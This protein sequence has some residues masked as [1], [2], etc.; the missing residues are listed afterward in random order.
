MAPLRGKVALV[1]GAARRLGRRLSLGLAEA[2]AS[3][4]LHY[5]KSEP[6]ASSLKAA[7]EASGGRAALVRADLVQADEA[8]RMVRDAARAFGRLD[9]LIN[10]ASLFYPTALEP[11]AATSAF[12]ELMAVNARAP[13]LAALEAAALMG[14][15]GVIV[16]LTDAS[17][18]T[19]WP[20]YVAYQCSKAALEALTRYLARALA[21]RIR[22]NAVAPGPVL[23]PDGSTPADEERALRRVPLG[24]LALAEDVERAVL[25]LTLSSSVTGAVIPV[26][27][28]RR[29][30]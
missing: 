10:N 6:E 16:N 30:G 2:G 12:D 20:D 9:I 8:R 18:L 21:P 17:V 5:S 27:G 26:D 25:F 14:D 29:I 1:T 4:V 23:M 28:G 11:Q 13:Y 7:I 22:V 3:V 24:K 15:D 19:P